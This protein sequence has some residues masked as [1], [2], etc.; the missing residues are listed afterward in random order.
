MP[1]NR[2]LAAATAILLGGAWEIWRAGHLGGLEAVVVGSGFLAALLA[3]K[4]RPFWFLLGTG[5]GTVM[6]SILTHLSR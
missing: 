5:F 3:H 4:P 2:R 1:L 6:G